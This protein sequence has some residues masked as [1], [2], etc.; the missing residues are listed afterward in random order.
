[1]VRRNLRKYVEPYFSAV[2][3]SQDLLKSG[4]TSIRFAHIFSI[5]WHF[6]FIV[7]LRDTHFHIRNK[8]KLSCLSDFLLNNTILK[9]CS[10][11]GS[12][13]SLEILHVL[14]CPIST[15][16]FFYLRIGHNKVITACVIWS[17][18]NACLWLDGT[19]LE[20]S[21][22]DKEVAKLSGYIP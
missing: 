10:N 20:V 17:E 21:D 2:L 9:I 19:L 8:L 14:I 5:S 1:M 3:F 6:H 18:R 11:L 15:Y 4:F 13:V 12:V 7:L 16:N 22:V